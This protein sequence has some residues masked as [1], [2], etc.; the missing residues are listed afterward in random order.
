VSEKR[1]H[2]HVMEPWQI[3]PRV[4][5]H[6]TAWYDRGICSTGGYQCNNK[7]PEVLHAENEANAV[8]IV[9][10]VNAL[11]GYTPEH[12]EV[13][14]ATANELCDALVQYCFD[15]DE[16]MRASLRF[17]DARDA[18]LGPGT[19]RAPTGTTDE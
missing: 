5:T 12:L 19:K 18:F 15:D 11:T 17:R 10:C 7:D 14:I 13:F 3:N 1:K 6:I 16:A 8:R 2:A 9:E 4:S